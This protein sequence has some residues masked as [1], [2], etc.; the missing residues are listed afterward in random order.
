M[1][2]TDV[3]QHRSTVDRSLV[4]LAGDINREHD[5]AIGYARSAVEHAL[6]C[7]RMLCDA[8]DQ[9]EHGEFG[10]WI[11]EHCAVKMRQ[12]QKY[13]RL[14]N[15]YWLIERKSAPG[16]LLTV[17]RALELINSDTPIKPRRP[18]TTPLVTA[19]LGSQGHVQH[20]C[21]PRPDRDVSI[22]MPSKPEA[23]KS[24]ETRPRTVW[25]IRE[26]AKAEGEHAT[27][28]ESQ[29]MDPRQVDTIVVGKTRLGIQRA[30]EAIACLKRIPKHDQLRARALEVVADWIKHNA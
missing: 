18:A 17:A 8:K 27:D 12:A 24:P 13:M 28:L 2:S 11:K 20:N 21:A 29:A 25:E 4:D 26:P 19:P 5:A 16:A 30:H 22:A 10:A 6:R 14:A 7:G 1:G 9:L 15:N 3:I 23:T